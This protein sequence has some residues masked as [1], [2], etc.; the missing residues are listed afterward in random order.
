MSMKKNNRTTR[1]N[2]KKTI[3][4]RMRKVRSSKQKG[5]AARHEA[6]QFLQQRFAGVVETISLSDRE[7]M[8]VSSETYFVLI[9]G[10]NILFGKAIEEGGRSTGKWQKIL[11]DIIMQHGD[12]ED[13]ILKS[14]VE[15]SE[16]SE[17]YTCGSA[18]NKPFRSLRQNQ[19]SALEQFN[20]VKDTLQTHWD[21]KKSI[22]C[23]SQGAACLFY[24]LFEYP[25]LILGIDSIVLFSPAFIFR[26]APQVPSGTLKFLLSKLDE[27]SVRI[28]LVNNEYGLWHYSRVTERNNIDTEE[29]R[30]LRN[31]TNMQ[32]NSGN[33][34]LRC[35]DHSFDVSKQYEKRGDLA[36]IEIINLSSEDITLCRPGIPDKI[37]PIGK[38]GTWEGKSLDI[39]QDKTNQILIKVRDTVKAFGTN[40]VILMKVY[41]KKSY[42]SPITDKCVMIEKEL[43]SRMPKIM[44]CIYNWCVAG[45]DEEIQRKFEELMYIE[46]LV[47]IQIYF[48]TD[49]V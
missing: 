47:N 38:I 36:E 40:K 30:M 22:V 4:K 25:E 16:T 32:K 19:N 10:S 20:C 6:L 18:E 29:S 34:M 17:A 21:K 44:M 23:T 13:K 49:R 14:S 7:K 2:K 41:D 37:L 42:V 27:L 43:D 46:K 11:E 24:S 33:I 28:L 26:G 45:T 5:G 48:D 8:R 9:P 3:H 15:Y 39:I 12:G 35:T 31:Y 1:R